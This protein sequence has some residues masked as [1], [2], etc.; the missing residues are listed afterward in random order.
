MG[1]KPDLKDI[2]GL[3]LDRR[4][5]AYDEDRRIAEIALKGRL[6]GEW[7]WLEPQPAY[8]LDNEQPMLYKEK[9]Q[10]RFVSDE[11]SSQILSN[12]FLEFLWQDAEHPI[13]HS[14]QNILIRTATDGYLGWLYYSK[15][16]LFSE[17]ELNFENLRPVQCLR[18]HLYY[19]HSV[20]ADIAQPINF[21]GQLF[22]H[23]SAMYEQWYDVSLEGPSW[24]HQSAMTY[25]N[26]PP[27]EWVKQ[28]LGTPYLWGGRTA[29]GID[30]SGLAQMYFRYQNI[31][32]PRDADQQ[33]AAFSAV[34]EPR[35]GDLA[36]FDGHVGI[37]LEQNE[38]GNWRMLHANSRHMSVTVDT[39]SEGEYGAYLSSIL[40][41]FGRWEGE[42]GVYWKP[43]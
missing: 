30:C 10:E 6:E 4:V 35:A 15:P 11:Y 14:K 20:R 26:L 2:N 28:F 24:V 38:R 12:E 3:E 25:S 13:I 27:L 39:L 17:L 5:W 1:S 33:E 40:H 31:Y 16:T 18:G 43:K 37:L 34:T 29:W 7:E 32:I 19:E 36:F 23:E 22:A 42:I 9:K 21:G 41:G 8:I